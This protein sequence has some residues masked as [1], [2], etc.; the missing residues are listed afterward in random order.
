MDVTTVMMYHD[1]S[2]AIS[3][4]VSSDTIEISKFDQSQSTKKSMTLGRILD[5]FIQSCNMLQQSPTDLAGL[6]VYLFLLHDCLGISGQITN[7]NNNK[8]C[9]LPLRTV[10]QDRK[11]Q[12]TTCPIYPSTQKQKPIN[13]HHSW[14]TQRHARGDGATRFAI[15]PPAVR[16]SG[17]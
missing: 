7:N 2:T 11:K 8:K 15:A 3:V 17:N 14:A 4:T 12:I 6:R 16:G 1:V 10:L 9:P 5:I 13:C